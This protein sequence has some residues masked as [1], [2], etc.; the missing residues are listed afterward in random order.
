MSYSDPDAQRQYQREWVARRRAKWF[1]DKTCVDCG[2]AADLEL[3][4]I[5]PTQ[6]VSHR[7]WSWS[8]ERIEAEAAKCVVRCTDCH[9]RKSTI[10]RDRGFKP[11]VLTFEQAQEIRRRYAAGGVTQ[12]A[13]ADEYGCD[14]RHVSHIILGRRRSVA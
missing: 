2:G 3:D 4:H 9:E 14:R 10:E 6:K 8:W 1:A 12:Q 11:S 7:I 13:L 5:D